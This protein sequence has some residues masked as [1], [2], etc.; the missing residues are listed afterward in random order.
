MSDKYDL[1]LNLGSMP[2]ITQLLKELELQIYDFPFDNISGSDFLNK[3]T[4]LLLDCNN[5]MEQK[6][7]TV[8]KDTPSAGRTQVKDMK[9]GYI[10][11]LDFNPEIPIENS[12]PAV[13]KRYDKY[14]ANLK[15]CIKA[16]KRILITYVENPII[17]EDQNEINELIVEA[18][19][20]LRYKYPNK[21]INILYI[22][23]ND[24]ESAEFQVVEVCQNATKFIFNFY[25]NFSDL[26]S[27]RINLGILALAFEGI[28]LNKSIKQKQRLFKEKL[29]NKISN[30]KNNLK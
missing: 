29:L 9:T 30:F 25:Q 7:L 6:D 22:K 14:I 27:R 28:E 16:A 5:F 1:I 20:K 26:S 24:N 18:S 11:S 4:S 12:Y 15:I 13:K 17:K 19:I 21:N 23:N 2:I 3:M 8:Q 10:Y